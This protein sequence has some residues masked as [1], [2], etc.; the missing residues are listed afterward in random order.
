MTRGVDEGDLAIIAV[1]L[2]VHLVGTDVLGDATVLGLDD[3]GIA[4][5]VEQSGLAVVDVTHDRDDG[6][7]LLERLLATLIG[8]K[9]Q[10]EGLQQLAVFVFGRDDL[11]DIVELFAEQL[12]GGVIDRLGRRD[13]LTEVEEHLHQ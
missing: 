4:Q 1:D 10:V 6:R 5:R 12:K 8:A 3:I 9:L 7:P 13:H 11:D 2:G